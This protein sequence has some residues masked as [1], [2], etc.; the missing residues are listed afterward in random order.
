M[1]IPSECHKSI[2]LI[3]KRWNAVLCWLWDYEQFHFLWAALL[4]VMRWREVWYFFYV[5]HFFILKRQDY[6]SADRKK[7]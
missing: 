3:E 2:V 4:Y 1:K 7:M 5:V 6:Q